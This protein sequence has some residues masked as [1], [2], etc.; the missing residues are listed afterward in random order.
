MVNKSAA[1]TSTYLGSC[2][3][4]SIN[5]GLVDR[6]EDLAGVS[7]VTFVHT[8][9]SFIYWISFYQLQLNSRKLPATFRAYHKGTDN[10]A[11]GPQVH[12]GIIE[13]LPKARSTPRLTR[14]PLSQKITFNIRLLQSS[15]QFARLLAA[16][17][18]CRL[19]GPLIPHVSWSIAPTPRKYHR[20]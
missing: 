6:G 5:F 15:R 19:Q 20:I 4:R 13:L 3:R 9:A 2:C 12:S 14:E 7:S 10:Y 16:M 18:I 11:N 8:E 17:A 1:H